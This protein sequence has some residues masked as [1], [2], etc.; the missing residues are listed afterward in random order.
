MQRLSRSPAVA[1]RPGLTLL[2]I[3]AATAILAILAMAVVPAFSQAD[4]PLRAARGRMAAD[5]SLARRLAVLF[6]ADCTVTTTL[7]QYEL[8]SPDAD[9]TAAL[10]DATHGAPYRV[11]LGEDSAGS[12]PTIARVRTA[13][14][15]TSLTSWTF[16]AQGGIEGLVESPEVLLRAGAHEQTLTID[17]RTGAVTFGPLAAAGS[18]P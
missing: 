11:R 9:V 8:T 15:Q 18:T 13:I 16:N 7:T 10:A 17:Y 4:E 2:E 6:N 14:T 3:A 12:P 5:L 1:G